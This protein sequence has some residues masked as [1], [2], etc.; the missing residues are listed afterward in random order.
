MSKLRE[1]A[2][3]IINGIVPLSPEE[4]AVER[5]KVCKECEYYGATAHQCKVCWCFIDLKTKVLEAECP[6]GK[7]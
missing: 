6:T 7:W 2:F 3:Q 5:V 4:L 1:I